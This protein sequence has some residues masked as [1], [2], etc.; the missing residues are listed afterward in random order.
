VPEPQPPKR[1]YR[2]TAIMYAVLA[3]LIVVVAWLTGGS[4][5]RAVVW[6]V[7]FFVIATAWSFWRWRQRLQRDAA[8]ARAAAERAEEPRR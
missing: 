7:G 8:E 1:P 4:L 5:G 6:A 3:V 2:D